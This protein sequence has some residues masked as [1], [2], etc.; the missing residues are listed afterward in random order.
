MLRIVLSLPEPRKTAKWQDS[1]RSRLRETLLLEVM[2]VI[3]ILAM[4]KD[5][6]A[7]IANTLMTPSAIQI[8]GSMGMSGQIMLC[9]A[10]SQRDRLPGEVRP[11]RPKIVVS[12][13]TQACIHF[14]V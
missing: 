11:G 5:I 2:T 7:M 9:V 12:L 10:G 6:F 13:L 8:K 14:C 1:S 3:E 4:V